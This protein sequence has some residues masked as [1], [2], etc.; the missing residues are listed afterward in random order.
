MVSL[1]QPT[2]L[3]AGEGAA[4]GPL[5]LS[6]GFMQIRQMDFV[7]PAAKLGPRMAMDPGSY[8]PYPFFYSQPYVSQV[9]DGSVDPNNRV[10]LNLSGFRKGNLQSIVLLVQQEVD[11]NKVD[12][13]AIKN[14]LNFE[15]I[16]D[17][18]VR[19]NG[20]VIYRED[21][22]NDTWV[23]GQSISPAQVPS[24]YCNPTQIGEQPFVL[25]PSTSHFTEILLAQFNEVS[26]SHLIQAGASFD[27]QVL[28]I[29]FTTKT[30]NKYKLYAAY[31][32]L[33]TLVSAGG[34]AEFQF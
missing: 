5:A 29:E 19:F 1:A 26:F 22:D 15:K 30:T 10:T 6:N 32:Y 28:N 34:N 13:K 27:S 8:N 2:E 17:I 25:T 20:N 33:T 12:P 18:E 7:N 24:A 23:I 11:G 21:L 3:Y 9:F 4:S 16:S 31:N 14:P